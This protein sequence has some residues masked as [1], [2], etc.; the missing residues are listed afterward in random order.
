[1]LSSYQ[2]YKS[3]KQQGKLWFLIFRAFVKLK[4]CTIEDGKQDK[5]TQNTTSQRGKIIQKGIIMRSLFKMVGI[6]INF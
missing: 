3:K 4:Y 6:K 5:V 2:E 1:M